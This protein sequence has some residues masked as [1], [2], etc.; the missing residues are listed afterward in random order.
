MQS[1]HGGD[2]T[3]ADKQR[4]VLFALVYPADGPNLSHLDAET[5]TC[6]MLFLHEYKRMNIRYYNNCY[7]PVP[8]IIMDYAMLCNALP[9]SKQTMT[10]S[11]FSALHRIPVRTSHEK[12]VRPSVCQTRA[13]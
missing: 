4:L 2:T 12:G 1:V 8:A 3:V 13:L 5:L 10:I 11:I 6:T 7:L 9:T